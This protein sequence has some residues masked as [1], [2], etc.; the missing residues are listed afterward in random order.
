MG[1][2]VMET[3]AKSLE[4]IRSSADFVSA[5]GALADEWIKAGLGDEAIPS[6]ISFIEYNPDIDFGEPGPL[7]HFAERFDESTYEPVLRASIRRTPTFHTLWMLN[8]IMNVA[9]T[10]E[11]NA[12]RVALLNEV[13]AMPGLDQDLRSWVEDFLDMHT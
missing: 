4:N 8:R 13:L 11:E 12:D 1:P 6:I 2:N 7:V 10:A 3:V 5:S 9:E